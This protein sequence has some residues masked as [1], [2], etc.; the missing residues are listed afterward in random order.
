[1]GSPQLAV[2]GDLWAA[3]EVWTADLASQR[4][5]TGIV[6][7]TV[8]FLHGALKAHR[9]SIVLPDE[10]RYTAQEWFLAEEGAVVP[11]GAPMPWETTASAHALARQATHLADLRRSDFVDCHK[12]AEHGLRSAIHAPMIVRGEERGALVVASAEA[13][14]FG[15]LERRIVGLVAAVFAAHHEVERLSE[16]WA[17]SQLEQSSHARSLHALSQLI[18]DLSGAEG[19]DEVLSAIARHTSS[20]VPADRVALVIPV[21]SEDKIESADQTEDWMHDHPL[22][23]AQAWLLSGGEAVRKSL[24][25]EGTKIGRSMAEIRAVLLERGDLSQKG[26]SPFAE[27]MRIGASVPIEAEGVVR[28]ALVLAVSRPRCYSQFE[29]QILLHTAQAIGHRLTRP[30]FDTSDRRSGPSEVRQ[31]AGLG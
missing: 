12:L 23:D 19:F 20:I 10:D 14:G 7:S 2:D 11:A 22:A 29:L 21:S 31:S 18:R 28:G 1:M 6:R 17:R 4:N 25:V 26:Q 3:F 16:R 13:D 8:G 27:Q 5:E 15:E 9:T 30:D 24:R